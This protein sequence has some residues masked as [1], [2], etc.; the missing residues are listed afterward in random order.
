MKGSYLK[1]ILL[2]FAKADAF[3]TR[4][5]LSPII[6]QFQPDLSPTKIDVKLN[7]SKL[8]SDIHINR[9]GDGSTNNSVSIQKVLN[10][11]EKN[12]FILGMVVSISLAS[13][14]PSLGADSSFLRPNI[15]FKKFGVSIIF[16]LSGLSLS[17]QSLKMQ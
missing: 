5:L 14:V 17:L 13:T 4:P 12:F 6:A 8:S 11:V 9:G 16:F 1:I 10:F 2:I 15:L 3:S 7:D